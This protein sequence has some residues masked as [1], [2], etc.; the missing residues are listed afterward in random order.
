MSANADTSVVLRGI[1]HGAEDY[2]LKPVRIEELRNLWQ[3]VVRRRCLLKEVPTSAA[4]VSQNDDEEASRLLKAG[5]LNSKRRKTEDDKE[6][7]F[8]YVPESLF[9]RVHR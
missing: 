2:L 3:H 9:I 4:K 5:P 8:P 1:T 7:S 6:A